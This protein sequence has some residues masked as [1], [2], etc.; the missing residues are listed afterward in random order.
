M[1]ITTMMWQQKYIRAIAYEGWEHESSG[2]GSLENLEKILVREKGEAVH[3]LSEPGIA[4][5]TDG[6]ALTATQGG[7]LE[8]RQLRPE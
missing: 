7:N 5:L 6:Q 4:A 8:I 2:I 3:G 1:P